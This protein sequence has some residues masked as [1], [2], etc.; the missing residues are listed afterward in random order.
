MRIFKDS[1]I[2]VLGEI[3]AKSIPFLLLPYLTRR[4]GVAGYGELSYYQAYIALAF[5][6]ISMSQDGALARYIF[7]YG[8]RSKGLIVSSSLLYSSSVVLIFIIT[9]LLLD[10][11]ILILV[12][13]A[14]YS[15]TLLSM[16]LVIRQFQ[17]EPYKYFLIQLSCG[18]LSVFF[19][20]SIFEVVSAL[21]EYRVFALILS[22]IVCVII[23][24][25]I[26]K[27]SGFRF[28]YSYKKLS[29]G[30][31]FLL[32]FGGPLILHH[33]SIF[34]KGQLDR[35]FI[36]EKFSALEL[37]VY[38]S[39]YQLA[40][41]FM[42]LLMAINKGLMPHYFES[43]KT[44]AVTILKI[45]TWVLV[46]ILLIPVP[47]VFVMVLPEMLFTGLL[48]DDFAMA[49]YYCSVFILGFGLLMPYL[50]MVNFL[51]YYGKTKTIAACTLFS[52][53]IYIIS[54]F[55]FSYLGIEYVAWSMFVSNVTLLLALYISMFRVSGEV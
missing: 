54:L 18:L 42:I 37:G 21:A 1:A 12:A 6:V 11:Y 13:V 53:V 23:A 27:R 48:G 7:R 34:A 52:A 50:L 51:F 9:G 32:A 22:N 15:N 49:K 47:Y 35:L 10:C 40:S 55:C 33:L 46:S 25:F 24:A 36:Y 4:L 14:A 30:V 17:S 44:G 41:I 43:I 29:K 39:G 16:Q 8:G 28:S 3:L 5:I 31:C 19:T 2:Y 38:S 26:L 45:R 20:V